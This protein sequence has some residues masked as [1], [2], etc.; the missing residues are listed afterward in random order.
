MWIL[1][2][3]I[4]GFTSGVRRVYDKHLT[5]HFGNFSIAFIMNAFA[6][7]P[8]AILLFFFPLP[9]KIMQLPWRFWWP[10]FASCLVQ[11]PVQ[12]YL[13]IR[14]VRE[15]E[16]SSVMPLMALLPVFNLLT[17]FVMLGEVPTLIG[18]AGITLIVIGVYLLLKKKGTHM[19]SRPEL[20]MILSVFCT[21]IGASFDKIALSVSTPIFYTFAE[22]LVS[23]IFFLIL[24][25]IT[26]ES[27]EL[28][29]MR[30]SMLP[31]LITVGILIA[32][33]I[34]SLE[35]AYT[36]GPTSYVLAIRSSNFILVALWGLF[37]LRESAT[38]KKIIALVLFL[39]GTCLLA[40]A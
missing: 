28:K 22:I 1:F 19:K 10:L 4:S 15:G 11:Y 29:K 37:R 38:T 36:K 31:T 9:G 3:I 21:A 25:F 6:L 5:G 12:I 18:F 32:I 40:F 2:A 34:A 26:K 7:V 27:H 39:A 23:T 14:A 30:G 20:F 16:L 33:T 13:Y 24:I 35:V 8:M 17:S